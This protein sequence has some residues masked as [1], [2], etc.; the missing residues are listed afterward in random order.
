MDKSILITVEVDS[1]F[2]ISILEAQR[3][4]HFLIAFFLVFSGLLGW[5]RR[6]WL[7]R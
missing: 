5:G 2:F 1:S 7:F 6:F 3:Q 4:I